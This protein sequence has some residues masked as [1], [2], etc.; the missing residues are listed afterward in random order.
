[1]KYSLKICDRIINVI[2]HSLLRPIPTLLGCVFAVIFSTII[3][4]IAA[5][6]AYT[7]NDI[8]ILMQFY[9][10]GYIIGCI[11]EYVS[12]LMKDPA[13]KSLP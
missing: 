12:L 6:Y 7:I 11:Y 8:S 9:V 2:A 13:R 4:T 3:F 1:M 5:L 10:I